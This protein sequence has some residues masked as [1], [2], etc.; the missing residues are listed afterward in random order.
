MM[1]RLPTL[2]A[3]AFASALAACNPQM[4]CAGCGASGTPEFLSSTL[5][6]VTV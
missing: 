3:L 2:L 6:D 4:P 5:P 1:R